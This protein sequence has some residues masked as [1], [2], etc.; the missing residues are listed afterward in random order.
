VHTVL[1]PHRRRRSVAR[2]D[3]AEDDVRRLP[4]GQ[5]GLLDQAVGDV[6]PEAVDAAV[7]P[8]PQDV[9][10]RGADAGVVPVQVGLGDVE[11]V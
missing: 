10:E 3:P 5:V 8:E 6:H 4:V 7:Q 9:H 11:Q 1:V 2:A